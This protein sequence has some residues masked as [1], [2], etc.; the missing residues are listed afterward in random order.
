MYE[1]FITKPGNY[2]NTNLL[3]ARNK[4][5]LG[6]EDLYEKYILKIGVMLA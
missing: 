5:S 3:T 4:D 6:N 1:L 2:L